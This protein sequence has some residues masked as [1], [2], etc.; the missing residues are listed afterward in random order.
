MD[1]GPSP[2]FL[3]FPVPMRESRC[4]AGPLHGPQRC[5]RLRRVSAVS[6]GIGDLAPGAGRNPMGGPIRALS[7]P[8]LNLPEALR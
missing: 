4:R 3:P 5:A 2:G 6:C 7:G 8:V 1:S